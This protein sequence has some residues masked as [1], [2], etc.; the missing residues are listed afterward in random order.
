MM[1]RFVMAAWALPFCTPIRQRPRGRAGLPRKFALALAL[2]ALLGASNSLAGD[3]TQAAEAAAPPA[4]QARTLLDTTTT[5]A[6]Q[7]IEYP[8]GQAR[9]VA[10]EI[11]LAEGG[12][13]GWHTHP[14]GSFA[15]VLEGELE[16]STADRQHR[17]AAGQTLAE[18]VGLPH[19]GRNV[20]QGP[21][22]LV[23]FY[24]A[25]DHQ[26]LTE[27]VPAPAP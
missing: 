12:E 7:A 5:W 16:I 25:A 27:H 2:A 19:N 23:V 1:Q 6:G 15:Y 9:V 22:R 21:V 8:Q 13:T 18:V 24:T 4:M 17:V 14:F 20:G 3:A 11:E 26:A 10:L